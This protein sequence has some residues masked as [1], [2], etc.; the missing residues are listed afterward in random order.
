MPRG[1]VIDT[2]QFGKSTV[3]LILRSPTTLHKVYASCM[4][5]LDHRTGAVAVTMGQLTVAR[6][7][8]DT[9]D[10][11][12]HTCETRLIA[13]T[14]DDSPDPVEP[15]ANG[16]VFICCAQPRDDIALDL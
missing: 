7:E 15:P 6:G 11:D 12:R 2:S 14:V 16:S 1:N 8:L 9:F 3:S 10:V 5:C 13:G 4:Q